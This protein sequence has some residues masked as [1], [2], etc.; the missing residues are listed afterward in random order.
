MGLCV[1]LFMLVAAAVGAFAVAASLNQT[2][3]KF[4]EHQFKNALE[5]SEFAF[6]WLNGMYFIMLITTAT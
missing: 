6:T 2:V 3:H 4:Y 1:Y 5:W